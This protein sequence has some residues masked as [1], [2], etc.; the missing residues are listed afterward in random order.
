MQKKCFVLVIVFHLFMSNVK[1]QS[2]Y[3]Q[4]AKFSHFVGYIKEDKI[5]TEKHGG[6]DYEVWLKNEKNA[7]QKQEPVFL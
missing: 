4:I 7:I 3:S 6:I 1:G 5:V 2:E